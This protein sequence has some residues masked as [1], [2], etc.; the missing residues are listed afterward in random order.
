MMKAS[1]V[2]IYGM[3]EH[4]AVADAVIRIDANGQHAALRNPHFWKPN[5]MEAPAAVVV[6]KGYPKTAEIAAAY[7]ARGVPVEVI[8]YKPEPAARPEPSPPAEPEKAHEDP[9]DQA[10]E[11]AE[12]EEVTEAPEP[13]PLAHEEAEPEAPAGLFD[14]EA[15]SE[16]GTQDSPEAMAEPETKPKR[17]GPGRPR[18]SRNKPR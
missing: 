4:P 13:E 15:P 9:P 5:Q 16:P 2:L 12:P 18:G 6:V 8:D 11:E 7:Q 14:Q 17:R 3:S 10:A 1:R